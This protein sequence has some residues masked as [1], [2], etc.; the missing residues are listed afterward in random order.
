METYT[1]LRE[2]ADSWFLIAM[3]AFFIGGGIWA[4]LPSRR[5]AREEAAG[6]PFRDDLPETD[7]GQGTTP[8]ADQRTHDLKFVNGDNDG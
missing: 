7:P 1:V 8:K 2:F 3:F 5:A 6:I 4:C